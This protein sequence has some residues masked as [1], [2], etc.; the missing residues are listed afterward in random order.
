[1]DSREFSPLRELR[2]GP[3]FPIPGFFLPAPSGSSRRSWEFPRDSV[4]SSGIPEFPGSS[5]LEKAEF[6]RRRFPDF[7]FFPGKADIPG[8]VV[9]PSSREASPEQSG[10]LSHPKKTGNSIKIPTWLRREFRGAGTGGLGVPSSRFFRSLRNSAGIPG[11]AG[12]SRGLAPESGNCR[13]RKIREFCRDRSR[14]PLEFLIP[15]L[16]PGIFRE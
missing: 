3:Q 2:E 16:F 13:A 14:D 10:I 15:G 5:E 6:R 4:E 7:P 8:E 9:D 11:G 1:M 12:T